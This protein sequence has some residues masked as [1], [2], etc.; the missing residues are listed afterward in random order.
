MKT[1]D[2]IEKVAAETNRSKSDA[3]IVFDAIVDTV[4]SAL[5]AKEEV[6]LGSLGKIKVV[7]KAAGTARNPA[8]GAEIAVPAKDVPKF[9]FGKAA[10]DA[11][12]A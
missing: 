11:V 7:H 9:S 10:K 8:T 2:L 6:E 5:K 4:M 1:K 12:N 3:K